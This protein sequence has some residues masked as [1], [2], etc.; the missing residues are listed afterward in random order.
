MGILFRVYLHIVLVALFHV[1][2]WVIALAIG[3]FSIAIPSFFI[4]L[5]FALLKEQWVKLRS[6]TGVN[7]PPASAP[8][9]VIDRL[10]SNGPVC[11]WGSRTR[12]SDA[13]AVT[14][15]I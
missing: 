7:D 13:W 14:R 10:D 4:L 9:T 12:S 11:P 15:E 1:L 3:W 8:L 2:I 6:R 5:P